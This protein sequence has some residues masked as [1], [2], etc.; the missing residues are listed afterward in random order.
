M[1]WKSPAALPA[2]LV[3]ALGAAC[4]P[5]SR[6]GEEVPP[7]TTL[8]AE[9]PASAASSG[10]TN[11][12]QCPP[13]PSDA[14]NAIYLG[15]DCQLR[16]QDPVVPENACV[17]QGRKV[18]WD[19]VADAGCAEDVTVSVEFTDSNA[20]V[21]EDVGCKS[22]KTDKGKG[23]LGCNVKRSAIVAAYDYAVVVTSEEHDVASSVDPKL[24]VRPSGDDGEG[25]GGGEPDPDAGDGSGAR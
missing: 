9:E 17:Y 4:G 2:V 6:S 7:P 16:A 5:G 15:A 21:V 14:Q 1:Q 12:G 20:D 18:D 3:L 11:P 8:A 19:V 25:Q 24:F 23:K 22:K 10:P 13:R